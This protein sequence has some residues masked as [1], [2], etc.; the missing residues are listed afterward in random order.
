MRRAEKELDHLTEQH[1]HAIDEAVK[2][3]ESELL[4]V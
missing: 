1:V 2:H 4:E 3:K